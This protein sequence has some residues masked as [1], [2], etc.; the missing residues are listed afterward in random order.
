M[1][2]SHALALLV[3]AVATL[4]AGGCAKAPATV[5]EV[6]VVERPQLASDP[7]DAAW[8]DLP[9]HV[10]AL[11]LQDMVD[12]RLMS[13]STTEV[14]VKAMTDGRALA[15]RLSW[16]D[17]D[18]SDLPGPARFTDACAVQLPRS[19]APDLPAPQMGEAAR[20]V[21]I[22]YWRASW[23]AVVAGRPDTVTAHYPNATV[24]HYPF[25]ASPLAAGSAEQAAAAE[26]YAPARALGN[27]MAGPRSSPVECLVAE[28]PGT[29]TPDPSLSADGQGRHREG[30]W[31][32]VITRP[33]PASLPAPGR[34]QV[35]FAVW[36]GSHQE[37]GARKMRTGWVALAR[38]GAGT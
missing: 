14:R 33:L 21:E 20:P 28:G 13:A 17:P 35:A 38:P 9:E 30:R 26:R 1:T 36:E 7:S 18:Q 22:A 32:V 10:A 25:E 2:R 31:E 16:A 5:P 4:L 11:L 24:D 29:L 12:P 37:V 8:L 19:A 34:G 27:T 6:V 15:F 3:L 23:Q